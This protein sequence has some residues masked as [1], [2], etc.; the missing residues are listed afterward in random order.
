MSIDLTP[1]WDK[2]AI[3]LPSIQQPFAKAVYSKR[4]PKDR[5]FPT[6]LKMSDLDFINPK[7]KLWHY[8]YALYSAGQFTDLRNM[9]CAV[10]N[11]DPRVLMLGDSGGFQIGKGSFKALDHL[12]KCKT[13]AEVC[14]E[15]R[16]AHDLRFFIVRW[17][18]TH[19]NYAMTIDMPLW[20]KLPQN[21]HTPFHKCSCQ[22]QLNTDT[23]FPASANEY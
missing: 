1:R 22:R 13:G 16:K 18:E 7:S 5:V 10:T 9:P 14:D 21:A 17:L 2:F 15:W 20:A 4:A 6:G 12:R 19:C 3:Y 11:R 23:F 8:G